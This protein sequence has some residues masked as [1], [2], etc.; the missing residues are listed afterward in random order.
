MHGS[1]LR[2]GERLWCTRAA[3]VEGTGITLHF[4]AVFIPLRTDRP[5]RRR[6]VITQ[7][8][9]IANLSVFLAA[10]IGEFS[11][12]FENRAELATLAWLDPRQFRLWQLLSYQFLHDP[13]G[14]GHIIFNMLF[15]WVFGSAVED[16]LGRWWFL[17]FYLVGGAV[18]GLAHLWT[19]SA[20]VIGASGS[21]AAVSGAF[22]AMF[23]RSRIHVLVIFFIIG[24]YAIPATW[25]LGLFFAIDLLRATGTILT[26]SHSNVAFMAHIGGY[27]Y[28]FGIAFA[29]L[30]AGVLKRTELD[31]FYLLRQARR[32][33]EFRAA[34]RQSSGAMWEPSAASA[35]L[36]KP[37][38]I[39]ADRKLTPAEE[40]RSRRQSEIVRLITEH[41]LDDAAAA[42][43]S[44]LDEFPDATLSENHQTDL[45]NV[46]YA[47]G[48]YADAARAYHR[49]LERYPQSRQAHEMRLILGMIHARQL[50]EPKRARELIEQARSG[51]SDRSQRDLADQLLS[52]LNA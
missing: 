26:G 9:I 7:A 30:A 18:A 31:A 44:F 36:D 39:Q 23:P 6:P 49:L 43:V 33:A 47:R 13:H 8:L 19:S 20:P 45:A 12:F 50:N 34:Q 24:M 27:V 10:L 1:T 3:T 2:L 21:V 51:L 40:L 38:Q 5:T 28:G 16:R 22:L 17:L 29:L 15:L 14:Y 4:R 32:R 37:L 41:R 42:Y 11:G 48:D 35:R 46:L 25:F 52:E